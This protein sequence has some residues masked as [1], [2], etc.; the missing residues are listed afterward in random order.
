M[1][2][3]EDN[4]QATEPM[5][6]LQETDAAVA[7]K[8][9]DSAGE[10][11]LELKVDIMSSPLFILVTLMA[12]IAECGGR[13]IPMEQKAE[14]ITTLRKHV[15]KHD[16]SEEELQL[17]MRDA[18]EETLRIEYR[19]YLEFVTPKLSTGQRLA[20][21]AN[22]YD[23][24]MVDGDLLDGEESRIDLCRRVF[25]LNPD[26]TRQIR[27]ILILKN[28]TSVF[29]NPGHPGNDPGFVFSPDHS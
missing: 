10:E 19:K 27:R 4:N 29:L 21:I 12:Y 1:M 22:L 26:V 8:P 24:M 23:M 25:D 16:I 3:D 28:D 17:M 5:P 20:I 18:F 13:N 2:S 15:N 11:V 7:P 9:D 6:T 14:F